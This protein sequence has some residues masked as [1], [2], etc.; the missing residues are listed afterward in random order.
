M[1]DCSKKSYPKQCQRNAPYARFRSPA[2]HMVERL[3]RGRTGAALQDL[4]PDLE[5]EES[6]TELAQ[7]EAIVQSFGIG[8]RGGASPAPVSGQAR[9]GS[10]LGSTAG[11]SGR[12]SQLARRYRTW[13]ASG[14]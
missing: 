6:D 13:V 9:S 12:G 14:E 4:A 3:R 2:G 1:L 11:S 10:G 8:S 5:V 7:E